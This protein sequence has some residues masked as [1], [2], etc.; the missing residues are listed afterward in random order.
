MKKANDV[1]RLKKLT[2]DN[3]RLKQV[4]ADQV[5]EVSALKEISM[6][7]WLARGAGARR[8]RM[9]Q[10]RLAVWE[11]GVCRYAASIARRGAMRGWSAVTTP[12]CGRC[13]RRSS[14]KGSGGVSA[15]ASAAA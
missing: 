5:L 13:W 11:R 10:D 15:R 9:L 14:A 7:N 2:Q 4:V 12:A 6:G 3:A 1:K 8:L